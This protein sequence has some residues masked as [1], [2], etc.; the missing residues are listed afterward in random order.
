MTFKLLAIA[1]VLWVSLYSVN[2][3]C[4]NLYNAGYDIFNIFGKRK[5]KKKKS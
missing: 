2:W 4:T 3:I 5:K 1:F